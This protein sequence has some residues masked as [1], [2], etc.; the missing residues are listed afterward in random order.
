MLSP[1]VSVSDPAAV[2][3]IRAASF[4]REKQKPAVQ[5]YPS[6]YTLPRIFESFS[7]GVSLYHARGDFCKVRAALPAPVKRKPAEI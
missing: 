3:L 5:V 7:P 4:T 1:S 6:V 2:V